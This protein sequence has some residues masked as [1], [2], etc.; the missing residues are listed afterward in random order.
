LR[1]ISDSILKFRAEQMLERFTG[2]SAFE[3]VWWTVAPLLRTLRAE[4]HTY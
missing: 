2:I 4:Q 1:H 3:V